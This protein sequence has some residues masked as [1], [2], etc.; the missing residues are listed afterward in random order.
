MS[1]LE[2]N[3]TL[4]A[5]LPWTDHRGERFSADR[6]WWT[7]RTYEDYRTLATVTLLGVTDD[8]EATNA[9]A[10]GEVNGVGSPVWPDDV[11]HP[12]AWF[13]AAA[14]AFIRDHDPD[15]DPA[16][17]SSQAGLSTIR[18]TIRPGGAA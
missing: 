12:P 18:P 11:P 1:I 2:H 13:H 6:A 5:P 14:A 10:Y 9:T 15:L 8:G 7:V 16:P 4:D 3:V 17:A